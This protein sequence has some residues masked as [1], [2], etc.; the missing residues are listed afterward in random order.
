[1]NVGP[2]FVISPPSVY[3][4]LFEVGRERER[5][6]KIHRLFFYTRLT[7]KRIF[8]FFYFIRRKIS[9]KKKSFTDE[10]RLDNVGATRI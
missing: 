5:E 9:R 8:F 3:I 10:R 7:A 1:M 2:V 4:S 6:R